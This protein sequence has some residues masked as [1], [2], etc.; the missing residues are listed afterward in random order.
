MPELRRISQEDVRKICPEN[1][2]NGLKYYRSGAVS[3]TW[4]TPSALYASVAGSGAK[5]YEAS[6]GPRDDG[7]Y[8]GHCTCPAARRQSICKH[9][10]AVLIAWAEKPDGFVARPE[11]E[12]PAAGGKKGKSAPRVDSEAK[13]TRQPKVERR[14]LIAAGLE[15]AHSLL[16]DLASQGLLSITKEQVEMIGSLA[17]TLE[18]HKLRRLARQVVEI[19]NAAAAA[20]ANSGQ[21]DELRWAW[22]LGDTWFVLAAT[23]KA[24]EKADEADAA[25][26]EELIGK[27]WL[28]KDLRR[29]EN[30]TLVELAYETL[31]LTSGFRVETSYLLDLADGAIYTEKQITPLR[32]KNVPA[33]RSY[34]RPLR[35]AVAGVYPGFAPLRLKLIEA[36]EEA[37]AGDVWGQA[38]DRAETSATALR[39][40]LI[41][42]TSSPVAPQEVY[43][44]FRPASVLARESS[45]HLLDAEG[46]AIPI[47]RQNRA[48]AYGLRGALARGPLGAVFGRMRFGDGFMEAEPLSVILT[49]DRGAERLVRLTA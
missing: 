37:A 33:K 20:L 41:A 19:Q 49:D 35:V 11:L 1:F 14:D 17:Q 46:R 26:L 25:E 3:N 47:S 4:R 29:A 39:Q 21:F 28:E 16:V 23:R 36:E 42:A 31:V 2:S 32:L 44:L 27:T 34:S 8:W 13:R 9:A 30:L 38:V 24:L 6:I 12:V 43:S 45:V 18:A 7:S 40:R 5:P 10:T 15:K 22:L 48:V